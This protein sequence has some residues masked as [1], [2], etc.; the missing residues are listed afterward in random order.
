M[1]LS[2]KKLSKSEWNNIEI[3]FP[4]KEKKILK[5]ICDGYHNIDIKKKMILYLCYV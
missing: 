1:D 3:P 4:E 2:Q 5:L